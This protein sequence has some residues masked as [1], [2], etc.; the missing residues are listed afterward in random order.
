MTKEIVDTYTEMRSNLFKSF[1]WD[2]CHAGLSYGLYLNNN[3]KNKKGFPSTNNQWLCGAVRSSYNRIRIQQEGA[4]SISCSCEVCDSHF[5]YI[6][7]SLADQLPQLAGWT[8]G[9]RW[10]R[11]FEF[12]DGIRAISQDDF[13]GSFNL[14]GAGERI[15]L[16]T[17]KTDNEDFV[18]FFSFFRTDE[19]YF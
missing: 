5:N 1:C 14:Y 9:S 12:K 16:S 2:F 15:I 4:W 6:R 8:C 7:L 10:I 13:F 19:L 18:R 17:L 11:T 3:I